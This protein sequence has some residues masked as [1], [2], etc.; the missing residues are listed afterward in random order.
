MNQCSYNES[1][2]TFGQ[3]FITC[4]GYISLF[5]SNDIRV[6]INTNHSICVTTPHLK[7]SFDQMGHNIGL[8]HAFGRIYQELDQN[9]VHIESGIHLAKMCNRGVTFTSLNRSLIYLVDTSGCKTTTERFRKLGYDFTAD[10]FHANSFSGE[11]ARQ[12]AIADLLRHSNELSEDGSDKYWN[13][14]GIS[15]FHAN[16]DYNH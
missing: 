11:Y 1:Y 16:R 9:S 4:E 5:V 10:I 13:L 8:I 7:A 15:V 6:D 2:L 12:R 14:A 3:P